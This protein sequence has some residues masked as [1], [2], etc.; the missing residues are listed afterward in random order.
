M[1]LQV[2][3]SAVLKFVLFKKVKFWISSAN[4][5]FL[6]DESLSISGEKTRRQRKEE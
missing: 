2:T 5:G 4:D 1:H 6:E 3:L